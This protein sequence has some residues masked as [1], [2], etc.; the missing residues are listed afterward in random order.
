M[1]RNNF[2]FIAGAMLLGVLGLVMLATL[3]FG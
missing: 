1:R 3:V 2:W